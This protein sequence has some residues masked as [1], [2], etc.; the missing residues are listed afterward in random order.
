MALKV[1]KNGAWQRIS[2]NPSGFMT[3]TA[4]GAISAGDPAIIN[5]DGTVS[6]VRDDIPSKNLTSTNFIGLSKGDYADGDAVKIN[7]IGSVD[8]NQSGLTAG[9]LYYVQLNGS[10]LTT[11]DSPSVE[12][13]IALNSTDLL[14]KPWYV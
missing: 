14:L 13:G 5:S 8:T 12:A 11:A 9:S 2:S 6:K 10:L 1:R 7:T 3:A 4:D